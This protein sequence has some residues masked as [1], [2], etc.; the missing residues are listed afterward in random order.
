MSNLE[1][2]TTASAMDL[3]SNRATRVKINPETYIKFDGTDHVMMSNVFSNGQAMSLKSDILLLL[4]DITEWKTMGE[5]LDAWP[6]PVD[7]PKIIQHLANLYDCKII[8]TDADAVEVPR[9]SEL[10]ESLSQKLHFNLDNHHVMLKD[11]V[12][13]ST[14]RRAIEQAVQPGDVVMDLG[15]GTGILGFFAAKAGA[16]KVY[17][18]EK[19][20]DTIQIAEMIAQQNNITNVEFIN[21]STSSLSAAQFSPKPNLIVSEIL[22]SDILGE[23][24]LEFTKDARDRFLAPGG[25]L[26]PYKL[27]I[28]AFAFHGELHRNTGFEIA[29]F[30]DL[31]N[32]DFSVFGH[33]MNKRPTLRK[34]KFNIH[35]QKP[36]TEPTL[37]KSIDFYTMENTVFSQDFELEVKR[38]GSFVGYCCYFKAWLNEETILTNSPWA[39]DTHWTQVLYYLPVTKAVKVGDKLP[40]DMIYDG[41]LRVRYLGD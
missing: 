21:G 11:H 16:E 25:R 33:L 40:M 15:C 35:V 9:E 34:D 2:V 39:P 12:R 30:N 10:S 17:A 18:V 38:D 3:I 23:H 24:I 13:V 4:W 6:S 8:I 22:D 19:R 14:Y 32:L 37:V 41:T 31:Y 26:L 7:H 1:S 27:D 5:I 36:L 29:E 28:Y 20:S